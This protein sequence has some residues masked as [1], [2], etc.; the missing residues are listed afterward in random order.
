MNVKV[1]S[2]P[3]EVQ[4]RHPYFKGKNLMY[5]AM[6]LSKG[7][8]GYT[9]AF[10][11]TINSECTKVFSDCKIGIKDKENIPVD[12]L[13]EI[14]VSWAKHF[15]Q[16]NN[17]KVPDMIILYREGLSD[18]QAA[19]QLPR[20]E[21]PALDNMVNKIGDKTGVKNYRPEIMIVTVNKKINS[22]YFVVGK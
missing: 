12:T 2:T 6:S 14:Y 17:K 15:F 20:M 21:I 5:G 13:E 3:W 7:K 18:K 19:S 1:G 11:G 22:R 9:L 10:V 16:T 4:K 8:K